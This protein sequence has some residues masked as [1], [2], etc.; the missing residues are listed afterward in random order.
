MRFYPNPEVIMPLADLK[1]VR[2]MPHLVRRIA[3]GTSYGAAFSLLHDTIAEDVRKLTADNKQYVRP[4]VFFMAGEKPTD[5]WGEAYARLIDELWHPHPRILAFG[6]GDVDALTL[7][8]VATEGAFLANIGIAHYPTMREFITIVARSIADTGLNQA[9]GGAVRFYAPVA[10][11][12]YRSLPAAP[13][14]MP[15]ATPATASGAPS[16]PQLIVAQGGNRG[17]PAAG[18][19]SDPGPAS[20]AA[21]LA[22]AAIFPECAFIGSAAKPG[23]DPAAIPDEW[24]KVPDTALDGAAFG[25]LVIRAASLRGD[26]H[27]LAGVTR[28]DA[29]SIYRVRE[30]EVDAVVA[31]VAEGADVGPL[32]ALGA[33]QACQ[34][35]RDEVLK[36]LAKLFADAKDAPAVC[37]DLVEGV[38][39]RL[40]RRAGFLEVAP[41]E[42]STALMVA[43]VEAG[44]DPQ[45]RQSVLFGVGACAAFTLRDG[46]F[47]AP[48]FAAGKAGAESAL[49]TSIGQVAVRTGN[50]SQGEALLVCTNGLAKPMRRAEVSERL[51]AWWRASEVPSLPEFAWQLSFRTAAPADDR[52]A[53]CLWAR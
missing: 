23:T 11:P 52:T 50:L 2:T 37:Q 29:M 12:G 47:G 49:P 4:V 3:P 41:E 36:R 8:R 20:P 26:K 28:T 14:A 7:Q 22:P 40:A 45:Q 6:F 51:A 17:R 25:G 46:A 21:P 13:E 38:A 16:A 18:E 5:D 53:I 42:L 33:D 35:V 34:L 30:G 1:S 15:K 10:V 44:G 32:S 43:V 27:R 39:D 31:C 48:Y 24:H 9:P 19:P